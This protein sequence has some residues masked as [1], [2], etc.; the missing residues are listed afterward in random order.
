MQILKIIVNHQE[1]QV[2]VEPHE[3]LAH[4]LREKINLT[5]TKL[6]CE[7]ASCGA[8]TVFVNGKAV[9]SC[10]FLALRAEGAIIT[11]IEGVADKNK[12]HQLQE[13]FVEKGAI[14]CGYCTPGMIMTTLDFLK[15]NP[16]PTT[17]EI[18]EAISGNLC[19]CTGYVK[20][21]DAIESY[22]KD[23]NTQV[24]DKYKMVGENRPYIEAKKKVQ[25]TADY[26]DDIKIKNTLYCKF[27]RSTHAHA[28]ISNIDTLKA[29][30]IKGVRL[31]ITG[32]ELPVKF[33]VLPISQDETAMAVE[34]T[35]YIG[36]IVAAVIADTEAIAQFACEQIKID[37]APLKPFFDMEESCE[38]IGENEK[39]HSHVKFNNNIHKKAELR[40][41]NQQEGLEKAYFKIKE[42]FDFQGINHGFTEPHAATAYWDENGLTIITATQVPHYLHRYL[43]KVMEIPMN[44]VRVI[45]PYVGGGFGGKSD[46]FPHE[47]IIA[48]ASRVL[49]KPV[50]VRFNR[51]EVFLTN[52]GRHPT[53]IS[54]EMGV[55]AS[56]KFEVLDADIIIDGGAYGS[57]GV[58]TSYYNGV[59]LQAPY[60]IDNFG[61]RTRRV[62]TNKPQCGAMRGHG[63]VNSR[64]AVETIIDR[65]AEEINMDPCEMRLKNFL[66][67]KTLT[68]GQYRITSNG[69]VESLKKVM[70][71][72][73]WKEKFRK[74]PE[75]HGIGVACGFFISGSALP[76]HWNEY[77]QSVVHL[78]VDLDGRVLVTSGASD[79]GQGS[80]TMLAIIVAE[81]LGLSLDNIFV[82]AADTT[83]TPIDL[84]SYS[85]RVTFM[86]GNAAKTAAENLKEQI[87]NAVSLLH[88]IDKAEIN[89]EHE[90]IFTNDGKLSLTW[91]EA[92]ENATRKAGALNS[93]GAYNSPKLGGDF[94]GAGAGLSPSYSFGAVI[95]EVK[96]DVATGHV[97]IVDIWGAHDAGKALNPLAV[98]GQLEGSWHMGLGQA[99][100]EQMKFRDGLLV[101]SNLVDYKIPTAKDI[102]SIHTNIVETIDPEGPFGAKECGE[103]AI[104]P[105]IP[106]VANAI[107][108]A[109]GV[110][111]TSLPITSEEV[112]KAINKKNK[113]LE[114]VNQ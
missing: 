62:Y 78:K 114:T 63:A 89:F 36:E 70:E 55:S 6:G 67:E 85:S 46:P 79:I 75:G 60:K 17:E 96:V 29:K 44:R 64:Y 1:H 56:G 16:T 32:K 30:K 91:I 25:G 7:Q 81:V 65:L 28:K 5:G 10:I 2:L 34:K 4:V 11:T 69:S 72:S 103:G 50:R 35:R 88:N 109:V 9:Q 38:D 43:A 20:I 92:I 18:R 82:V 97:K 27:L 105:I 110:R 83:L 12:L 71:L 59:L 111:V 48:Y 40:F 57:F 84:G 23:E 53:K 108:D 102:P 77:P 112:L 47:M 95:T 73:K 41:G 74:L 51:E 104:H 100:S 33:G 13:K 54:M 80:D 90:K 101:N 21:V 24:S 68:V 45:K 106:A 14:Q 87:L 37:Y 61:F 49:G 52:H 42:K 19:R 22:V 26:A 15:E 86:A 94:K 66:N 107:Y 98:E 39:I 76:I 58:V 99:V 8:C 31:I 113:N 93:T 3:T